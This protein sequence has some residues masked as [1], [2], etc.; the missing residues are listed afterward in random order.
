MFRQ[1]RRQ[2]LAEVG[3]GMFVAGLGLGLA[4]ELGLA[5]AFA[6][7]ERERLTFGAIEP[8]VTLLQETPPDKLLPLLVDRLQQGLDL[9]Q[10]TA[11]GALANARAF[12]GEHYGGFHTFMA[13]VPA[14]EMAKELPAERQ[15]LPLLK[16]LYRNSAFLQAAG[17][18]H[19][20]TLSAAPEARTD[21]DVRTPV[22]AGD[23][24][25]AERRLR[26]ALQEAQPA[27]ALAAALSA[28]E[29]NHDVHT[30]VLPWRA[31]AMLNLTGEE[32]ALTLLRQ[33]VRKCAQQAVPQNEA[34][35]KELARRRAIVPRL[36]EEHKLLEPRERTDRIAE[37]AWIEQLS[38]TILRSTDEEAAAAVA[39]ALAEGFATQDVVEA[40]S[41]ASCALILRQA[42]TSGQY[43]KRTHGDSMG[44]H[45]SDATN[46][47]R[48]LLRICGW[49]QQAA[50][51]MLAAA[52][53][54][55]SAQWGA[56]QQPSMLLD[57]PLPHAEQSRAIKPTEAST[58][59][60]VLDEAIR[61]SDQLT[62]CAVMSR[63]GELGHLARDA[64]A[65]MLHYAISEDGRLHSEKYYRT[66]S[67]EYTA[68]RPAFRW[69][70]LVALARVTASSYGLDA[71]DKPTGRA[72]GYEQARELLG[73]G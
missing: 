30:V 3:G 14:Y 67:E 58:L 18:G 4:T 16:V 41:L 53:V 13:L 57:E 24:A 59:L 19:R 71:K 31:Y 66:V 28:V 70:H 46:A 9:R 10:L 61:N 15:P 48:N 51:L 69:R 12:G 72:P 6:E 56:S 45:A 54:A 34:R 65:V 35:A 22:N 17:N 62:A 73:L 20:D 32:H 43:G 50:G 8:L 44:V 7:D 38:S 1:T 21:F 39:V 68:L 36:L 29:D 40:I 25:E 11:A 63:Y 42:E 27:G 5:P 55:S 64:F 33:S 49:R 23:A 26:Y 47:W 37:E 60:A 2:F 52:N